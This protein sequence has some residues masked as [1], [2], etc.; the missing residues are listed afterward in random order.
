[1]NIAR[2][3]SA[4][5]ILQTLSISML[6]PDVLAQQLDF[7]WKLLSDTNYEAKKLNP[8]DNR[9][10]I[11]ILS[12]EMED[13][14]DQYVCLEGYLDSTW[15]NNSWVL[16]PRAESMNRSIGDHKP[17]M[18]AVDGLAKADYT[19]NECAVCGTFSVNKTDVQ[20][21]S[22][23]LQDAELFSLDAPQWI[24]LMQ[25]NPANAMAVREAYESYHRTHPFVKTRHTQAYKRWIVQHRSQLDAQGNVQDRMPAQ[26]NQDARGGG[27]IWTYAGP[28]VHYDSDGTMT[29]GFRHSNV[30][31]HDRSSQNPAILYCGTES[32]GAYK[33]LDGGAHW[34]HITGDLIIGDVQSLRVHPNDDNVVLMSAAND[35]WRT[36]NGGISWQ[37][38]GQADF[39][40]LNIRASEMAFSPDNP[41]IVYAATNLGFYLSGDGGDTWSEMLTQECN[42][43]AIKPN[44][45]S[46]VYT[47]QRVNNSN[48]KFYKSEDYGMTWTMY[49]TGWFANGLGVLPEGGRLAVTAAD[50]ER[51][52][53][54]LVGYQSVNA[55]VT[56][57]GWI[58]AWV[59]YDAGVTWALP[60]GLIGTPYTDAHPNLMN[61]QGDDGDYTQ[62]NYNTT[63]VASQV[64][65]DKVLIG[66][67]NLW[68][69]TDACATYE[70]VGGYIGGID[71]FHVDQQEYRIYLNGDGTEVIWFSNDGGIGKSN[72]FMASHDNLNN[73]I[74]AV[75]LWGY[76]QGWNEDMMVGGRY[77][78]GNMAYHEL[79]PA[80][81]FL[82]L[83][84][85]ESA[86]GY[87][88][89]SDENKTFHSDIGGY[90]IPDALN[91]NVA[92][93]STS[94]YP[95]E[96]YWNNSS[97]RILFDNTH[98]N[99]AWLGK[100]NALY[101]SLDGGA[102]FALSHGFSDDAADRVLWIEQS[103]SDA[104]FMYV[105]FITGNQ[106]H[107]YRTTDGGQTWGEMDIP[108]DLREMVFSV[109]STNPDE[110]WLAYYYGSNGAK[111]YHTMDAGMTW[112]N[113]TTPVLDGE[114]IW[115]IAHAYGTDGGIY[116]A[117][118][119][120]AVY[121]RNNALDDWQLY[122]SGLP[123]STEPLR[124][125]PFYKGEKVRLAT[126]NLGVW[127][128]P[129]YESSA[130]LADFASEQGQFQCPGT[131]MHFVNHSVVPAGAT[132]SWTMPG[133]TP[134]T[135][136]IEN[137][138]VVYNESG[139]YDVTL[140]VTYEGVTYTKT[141]AN[142][143]SQSAPITTNIAEDFENAG[144]G[145]NWSGHHS[146]GGQGNWQVTGDGSAFGV[147][148]YAMKFDNWYFDAQGGRDEIWLPKMGFDDMSDVTISFDVAYARYNDNWIDTLAVL[149]SA[150]CGQ[151]WQEVFVKGGTSLSTAPDQ[152][153]APFVPTSTQ[154]RSEE[155]ALTDYF[156][157]N[158]EEVIVA[159]QNRG[160]YGQW[161]YVDNINIS[162][163][164]S[165]FE[166][167]DHST[168][169]I[170]FPNPTDDLLHIELRELT[171]SASVDL[172]DMSG[173]LLSQFQIPSGNRVI[174]TM[175]VSHLPAGL[176][177]L[178]MRTASGTEAHTFEVK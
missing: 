109:G 4:V 132:Y 79:Y 3:F 178:R 89:Y 54:L 17:L 117:V 67:L 143:I 51:I 148:S 61:F 114:E 167:N 158:A 96:S 139:V 138:T 159:F 135:S 76:D 8:E 92:G 127:E 6:V 47:I 144:F 18:L 87:V 172:I 58:G 118:K 134:S 171:E 170:L 107:L 121:Y 105:H 24:R 32:G 97:S 12:N 14:I 82:A 35:L 165:I 38:I 110:V 173:K 152:S 68:M 50:P 130:V 60:H 78:N 80:G 26:R 15:I 81:E 49:D 103:Y 131:S 156:E 123:A 40:S 88:N 100:D 119:N 37:V 46:V 59:S 63:M 39:V 124:L 155:I 9:F 42:T 161:L 116:I 137:P 71:Y 21:P 84:G 43:L 163:P 136:D 153:D 122:A 166:P 72:D 19:P 48:S 113:I 106:S 126:W 95:N 22:F 11:P 31:C 45:P 169:V 85:G 77:H 101:K 55:T 75:N 41:D 27:E 64:D 91:G 20:R 149:V 174:K 145:A 93:F 125:V 108:S 53:A 30:Y 28:K 157:G 83:G 146:T 133:A 73:G 168:Q 36:E 33:T 151:S 102:T 62:I 99:T 162:T 66:G 94:M 140:S 154:W 112:E 150:D 65:P 69:S 111:V 23:I 86:T 2:I 177:V 34:S 90:V 52:Y 13:Y 25:Q 120:G 164:M 98:F 29:P 175:D 16:R 115:A 10:W 176:Y 1:M 44:D 160:Y 5:A 147:G 104:N 128:A 7:N 70:G 142:Y 56:T 74:Q 57:N 141:R 129:L